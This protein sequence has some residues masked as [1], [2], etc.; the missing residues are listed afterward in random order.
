LLWNQGHF[1]EEKSEEGTGDPG[2]L[3]DEASWEGD[4]LASVGSKKQISAPDGLVVSRSWARSGVGK[5]WWRQEE[6]V[7]IRHSKS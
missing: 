5:T 3:N 2:W 1:E 7:W 4:S 6:W